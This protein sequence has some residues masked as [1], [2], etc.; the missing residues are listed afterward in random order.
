MGSAAAAG[1]VK[2]LSDHAVELLAGL[3]RKNEF[4]ELL[5]ESLVSRRK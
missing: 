4:L 2:E 3:S 1:K 5:V